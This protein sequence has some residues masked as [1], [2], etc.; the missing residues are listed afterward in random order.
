MW[1]GKVS[2][3]NNPSLGRYTRTQSYCRKPAWP[4]QLIRQRQ[5]TDQAESQSLL[6]GNV[7]NVGPA[8]GGRT[9]RWTLVI[10][11]LRCLLF[12]LLCPVAPCCLIGSG[13][14]EKREHALPYPYIFVKSSPS[15]A[16][17]PTMSIAR[18]FGLVHRFNSSIVMIVD[19]SSR[20]TIYAIDNAPT[21]LGASSK[22]PP[23][24]HQ[25]I[26]WHRSISCCLVIDLWLHWPGL[27]IHIPGID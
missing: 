9:S 18:S 10:C 20:H 5:V 15:S 14:T 26:C 2:L 22:H 24:S 21:P 19:S 8:N 3:L 6:L 27:G 4:A 23:L 16:K 13:E 25:S 1:T 7:G 12:C 11:T 17:C